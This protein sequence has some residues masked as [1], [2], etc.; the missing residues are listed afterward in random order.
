[1]LRIHEII[2]VYQQTIKKMRNSL[3]TSGR[4]RVIKSSTGIIPW[5][6]WVRVYKWSNSKVISMAHK[7]TQEHIEPKGQLKMR[8]GLAED[9]LDK[10]FLNA[11]LVSELEMKTI[12]FH[13]HLFHVF[14]SSIACNISRNKYTK[15]SGGN[16]PIR[17]Y[18]PY[19]NKSSCLDTYKKCI[20]TSA[21]QHLY[22]YRDFAYQNEL[23]E[24]N[25]VL[26]VSSTNVECF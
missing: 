20:G 6:H 3:Y 14:Y 4:K 17:T 7:I 19:R 12:T 21:T 22:L 24:I 1:M 23:N 9:V 8:N 5:D 2:F 25:H 15:C 26:V 18:T 10:N 16:G 13:D 11:M